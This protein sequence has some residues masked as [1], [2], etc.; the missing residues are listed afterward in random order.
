MID[1][2]DFLSQHLPLARDVISNMLLI[3]ISFS[4]WTM[5]GGRRRRIEEIKELREQAIRH[6]ELE[7]EG[8][9]AI[10]AKLDEVDGLKEDLA[11]LSDLAAMIGEKTVDG[12]SRLDERMLRQRTVVR[13]E[14]TRFFPGEIEQGISGFVFALLI[15]PSEDP[16]FECLID[17]WIDKEKCGSARVSY[18]ESRAQADLRFPLAKAFDTE[19]E[20]T[21][22]ITFTDYFQRRWHLTPG[23]APQ[24]A[25]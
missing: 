17:L 25:V 19:V 13:V 11:K 16:I 15:N 3:F 24:E 23:L 12:Y 14:L 10:K 6:R 7:K 22:E 5:V 18:L 2:V 4:F 9:I 21:F 1:L 8:L 20:P